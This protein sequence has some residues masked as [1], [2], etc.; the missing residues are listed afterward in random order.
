MPRPMRISTRIN[1]AAHIILALQEIN[2]REI[3]PNQMIV[4]TVCSLHA[5]SAANVM[6][7]EAVLKGTIRTMD[8]QVKEFARQ[9]MR[10]ICEG[11]CSTFRATCD[12]DFIGGGIP[13]M[14]NDN[15]LA[16]EIGGY[17]D[18]MLGAGTTYHIERMTGSEDFSVFSQKS[19]ARCSGLEPAA[20]NKDMLMAF[21]I[22]GSH[23]MRMRSR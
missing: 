16:E 4:L 23:S 13:P 21:T 19:P 8:L 17:I 12:I 22:P 18:D 10:E 5:G 2:S 3:N 9:R 11:V 7:G 15:A 6:P 14:V 1:A 20:R